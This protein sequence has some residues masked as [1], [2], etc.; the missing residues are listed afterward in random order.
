MF[1]LGVFFKG[2]ALAVVEST[3]ASCNANPASFCHLIPTEELLKMF[4]LVVY[5]R[6]AVY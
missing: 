4:A 5:T 6:Q 3:V 1:S 2:G